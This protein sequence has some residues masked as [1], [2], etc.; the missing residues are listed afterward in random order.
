M[1]Q[2]DKVKDIFK[3]AASKLASGDYQASVRR[4]SQAIELDPKFELG[5][6]T[7]GTAYMKMAK[8]KEAVQD[9]G[10]ALELKPESPRCHHLRALAYHQLGD[11]DSA[12]QDFNKAI[13]L[14]P[15]YGV[16][17]LS[18]ANLHEELENTQKALEDRQ[19]VATLGKVN[20]GKYAAG[21][22]VWEAKNMPS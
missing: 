1:T 18:R 15:E 8:P 13:E 14:D 19:M 17:Y 12:L 7:R 4:I 2:R 10:K 6:M 11:T 20:I 16:A 22:N 21:N 9:F 5:Y 3:D